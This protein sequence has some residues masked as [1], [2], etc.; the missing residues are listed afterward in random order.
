[1]L[2]SNRTNTILLVLILAAGIGII[3]MLAPGARGGPLDPPASPASTD[4]VRLPG[5]PITAIPTP[6]PRRATTT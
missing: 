1:M 4:G 2:T 5:T 6:S 3:A